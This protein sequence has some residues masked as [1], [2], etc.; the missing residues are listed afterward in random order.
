MT[1]EQQVQWLVDRARIGDRLIAFARAL[2]TRDWAAYVDGYADGGVLD[3]PD[4]MGSGRIV[5]PKDRLP[6]FVQGL[7]RYGGTHHLSTNHEIAIDGDRATSRSYLQAVHVRATPDDHW[8][9]G[10]WY[11]C[12]YV[13]TPD[14]WKFMRVRLSVVWMDGRPG[15]IRPEG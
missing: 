6:E 1:L 8:T 11:D 3:L 9:G 4:P 13:R 14:G 12:E 5:V 10:G 2:D 7:G 15:P